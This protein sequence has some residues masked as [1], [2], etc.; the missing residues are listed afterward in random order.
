MAKLTKSLLPALL[1]LLAWS[2]PAAALAATPGASPGWGPPLL[3]K[4]P[5]WRVQ[6][7]NVERGRDGLS[8]SL[9]FVT[10]KPIPYEAIAISGP[11]KHPH[12]S[13][14]QPPAE[15]QR[16]VELRWRDGETLAA[17]VSGRRAGVH[18]HGQ[19]WVELPVLGTTAEV[20]TRAEF[21]ANQGGPGNRDMTAFWE[22]G[23]HL[24]ELHAAVPDQA[25]FEERLSWLTEVDEASWLAAMPATVVAPAKHDAAVAAMLKGIPVPATFKPSRVPDDGLPTDRYQVGA[26]VTGTVSCLWFRQWGEARR[27]GDPAA[28]A[29]AERAMATSR[30]WAILHEMASE[31]A[32]PEVL[33]TLA[34]EMPSGV[35]RWD[36]KTHP[37]L[38]KTEALGCANLG[39]PVLPAKMKAQRERG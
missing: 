17:A 30:H 34:R 22:L 38:P 4:G 29:E 3:L 37:L 5:G 21:F 26:K 9:E 16:R 23:G 8:G 35:W 31:G 27:S 32:Y 13:G 25:A 24:Y 20:D 11:A 1:A 15:R 12:V 10:G 36:G 33:W 7:A 2:L 39:I 6:H 18:P 28:E 19:E 14:M